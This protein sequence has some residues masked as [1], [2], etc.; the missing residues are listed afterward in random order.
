MYVYLCRRDEG[1]IWAC[2]CVYHFPSPLD[3]YLCVC[4]C[5]YMYVNTTERLRLHKADILLLTIK[6]FA[7]NIVLHSHS[8]TTCNL[9]NKQNNPT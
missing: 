2:E 4:V 9:I 5:M 6:Y 3:S 1:W 8:T 7:L